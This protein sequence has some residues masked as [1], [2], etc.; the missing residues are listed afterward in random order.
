MS[1]NKKKIPRNQNNSNKQ[2]IPPIKNKSAKNDKKIYISL[3]YGN[4]IKS[5]RD[6]NF[7]NFLKDESMFVSN[8]TKI[9]HEIIPELLNNWELGKQNYHSHIIDKKDDAY[10]MYSVAIKNLHVNIDIDKIELWGLGINGS[11]RLICSKVD[12]TFFLLLIDYHHLGYPNQNY[13]QSDVKK[14]RYCPVEEN[15]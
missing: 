14:Y 13:N 7:T 6:K 1:K 8:I 4:W 2:L 3:E 12:A 11:I 5:Y 15:K 9:L 10:N